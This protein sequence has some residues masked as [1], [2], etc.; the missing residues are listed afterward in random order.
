MNFLKKI[1]KK[2]KK[3]ILLRSSQ[4]VQP[5]GGL[6]VLQRAIYIIREI[7]KRDRPGTWTLL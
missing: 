7:G 3:I 1:N 2:Q 6:S 5:H 4:T